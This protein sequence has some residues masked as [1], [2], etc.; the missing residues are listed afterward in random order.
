M[1]K[2]SVLIT[3]SNEYKQDFTFLHSK[4]KMNSFEM[5]SIRDVIS[6]KTCDEHCVF[7]PGHHTHHNV[8]SESFPK[9]ASAG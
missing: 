9:H 1:G 4:R 2:I 3:Q 5:S 7:P 6:E 8:I